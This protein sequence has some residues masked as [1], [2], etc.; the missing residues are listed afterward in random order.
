MG[1]LA[2]SA[3]STAQV[4]YP[5]D[6]CCTFW[7]DPNYSGDTK[8]YCLDGTGATLEFTEDHWPMGSWW[9]GKGVSFDLCDDL[10]GYC[11][12]KWGRSGTGT[13]RSPWGGKRSYLMGIRLRPYDPSVQGAAVV[14]FGRDCKEAAGRLDAD[15]DPTKSADYTKDMM[16]DRNIWQDSISSVMV[17]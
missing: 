13:A 12:G 8:S 9:C 15:S 11:G 4:A 16:W 1:I 3:L 2:L 14:F 7:Y 6:G 17:P 10:D 5:G